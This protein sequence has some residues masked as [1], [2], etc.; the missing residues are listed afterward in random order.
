M[1]RYRNSGGDSGGH[2]YEIG[3]NGSSSHLVVLTGS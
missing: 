2:A 1:V 3:N